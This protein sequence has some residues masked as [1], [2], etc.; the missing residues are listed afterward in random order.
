MSA[1]AWTTVV[2]WTRVAAT[3]RRTHIWQ[4][5]YQSRSDDWLYRSLRRHVLRA[6]GEDE[7]RRGEGERRGAGTTLH[8]ARARAREGDG[9]SEREKNGEEGR[10]EGDRERNAGVERFPLSPLPP[11]ST[12]G[13]AGGPLRRLPSGSLEAGSS[14]PGC[15]LF[16][17]FSVS[18]SLS[19]ARARVLL[20]PSSSPPLSFPSGS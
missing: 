6:R 8:D 11:P 15:A 3:V 10:E 18:L 17:P 2:A 9:A 4:S 16:F 1:R 13:L 19:R 5:R 20:R 12:P 14:A 7:R